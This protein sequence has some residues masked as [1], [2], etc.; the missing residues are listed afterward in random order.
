MLIILQNNTNIAEIQ[1]TE[2]M[3]VTSP[4]KYL[5][6]KLVR[7]QTNKKPFMS[8]HLAISKESQS[9]AKMR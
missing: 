3:F 1:T 7:K 8:I 6:L 5:K 2:V 4:P 9:L